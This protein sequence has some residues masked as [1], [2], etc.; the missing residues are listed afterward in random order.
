LRNKAEEW[1]AWRRVQKDTDEG[2]LGGDFDRADLSNVQAEAET[3]EGEARD[4][5]W[6]SY[7]FVVLVDLRQ[8]LADLGL[9]DSVRVE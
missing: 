2:I 3:A 1:L 4:E 7:R 6:A 9:A 8:I 5:V